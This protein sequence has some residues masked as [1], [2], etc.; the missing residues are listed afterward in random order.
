MI[1]SGEEEERAWELGALMERTM[2]AKVEA[3]FEVRC[4]KT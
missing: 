3:E 4:W 1:E 2:A